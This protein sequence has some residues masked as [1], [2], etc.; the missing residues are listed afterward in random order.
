[1]W[2]QKNFKF[3]IEE[4]NW[5]RKKTEMKGS[6]KKGLKD[7]F[8]AKITI[9]L[10]TVK[11]S[12]SNVA[13]KFP[14]QKIP[15]FIRFGFARSSWQRCAAKRRDLQSKKVT[16][17]HQPKISN[18]FYPGTKNA[19]RDSDMQRPE[20]YKSNF[21]LYSNSRLFPLTTLYFWSTFIT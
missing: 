8:W 5:E 9:E 10:L 2:A 3:W 18:S 7:S 6:K 15:N 12:F 20:V 13:N 16:G 17:Y 4:C 19:L 14:K 21:N 11:K 1:M